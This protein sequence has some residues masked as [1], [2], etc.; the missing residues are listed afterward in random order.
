MIERKMIIIVESHG[1]SDDT[2]IY[3]ARIH[4]AESL[5]ELGSCTSFGSDEDGERDAVEGA[6]NSVYR[7]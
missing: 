7:D 6:V 1:Q 3:E 2:K 5:E 4:D